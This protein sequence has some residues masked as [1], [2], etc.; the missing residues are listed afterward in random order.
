MSKFS[1]NLSGQGLME[2]I[3]AIAVIITGISGTITL[4]YSNLQ[5]SRASVMQITAANLARE[6]IEVVRNIRDENWLQKNNWLFGLKSQVPCTPACDVGLLRFDEKTKIWQIIFPSGLF[7]DGQLYL[8]DNDIY[9]HDNTGRIT[10]YSRTVQIRDSLCQL[11]DPPHN[12]I[13]L[14]PPGACD[15]NRYNPVGINVISTVQW[16]E[17]GRLRSYSLEEFLYNW[18]EAY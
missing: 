18:Y 1:N 13:S 8:N 3:V 14:S 12:I 6:G 16:Q 7:V 10:P 9:T 17:D 11:K 4:T 5:G 15:V 2:I